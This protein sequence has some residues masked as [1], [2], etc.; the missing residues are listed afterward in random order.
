M[1]TTTESKPWKVRSSRVK[2][3]PRPALHDDLAAEPRDRLVLRLEDLDLGQAV[4][5]DAVAEHPA[6][7]RV[8]LEDG[9]VVAGQEQ[10]VG[11][12]HA[13]RAGAD[14]RRLAARSGLLLERHRRIDALVEHRL[15]DLVAGVAVRVADGDRLVDLVAPAVLLARRRA[16]PPEDATG[17]GSSA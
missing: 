16:D 2:S 4:L 9:H 7:R 14:D 3:R 1:A 5:R 8:A 12:A 10:V 6:G 13:G 15:E 11:G 17:T